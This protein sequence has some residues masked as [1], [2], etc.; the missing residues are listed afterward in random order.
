MYKTWSLN[1]KWRLPRIYWSKPQNP[2]KTQ[3]R[4]RGGRWD[5]AAQKGA[6]VK[7]SWILPSTSALKASR[8]VPLPIPGR[9]NLEVSSLSRIRGSPGWETPSL[10]WQYCAEERR[11]MNICVWHA[12]CYDPHIITTSPAPIPVFPLHFQEPL[13]TKPLSISQEIG[14]SHKFKRKDP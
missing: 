12:E 6:L 9:I 2:Q 7:S 13:N 4:N 3:S 8:G 1:L 14:K 10:K 5:I 11:G